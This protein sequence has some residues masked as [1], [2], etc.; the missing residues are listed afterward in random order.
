[1]KP[2][3]IMSRLAL[4]LIATLASSGLSPLALAQFEIEESPVEPEAQSASDVEPLEAA[5][6]DSE[7]WELP[8]ILVIRAPRTPDRLM[9]GVLELV[10]PVGEIVD[11]RE[12]EREARRSGLSATADA[13]LETMLQGRDITLIIIV[14]RR[15]VNR[16]PVVALS[17]REGRFGTPLLSAEHPIFGDTIPDRVAERIQAETVLAVTALT[18]SSTSVNTDENDRPNSP[19]LAGSTVQ[20]G[21]SAAGGVGSRGFEGPL[22][23][24]SVRLETGLFPSASMRIHTRY[25]PVARGRFAI[26]AELGYLTSVGLQTTDTR[27]DG[28][29]RSTSSRAQRLDLGMEFRYRLGEAQTAVTLGL[30]AGYA[31]RVFDTE[32]PV[33][34]PDYS[35]GSGTF[36]LRVTIPLGSERFALMLGPM[37]EWVFPIGEGLNT[38][39]PA[40]GL[41]FGGAA[42]LTVGLTSAWLLQ[43]AYQ[44]SHV[45]LQAPLGAVNDVERFATLGIIYAP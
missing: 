28:S 4:A 25:E 37:L 33:S 18:R 38:A 43:L 1:M 40:P 29:T 6:E 32:A 7:D 12:F 17:Y 39:D 24:G 3:I 26:Q 34:L 22:E 11:W 44:E 31:A 9:R 15:V 16:R 19:A 13:T 35:L 45:S 41:A 21:V 8:K 27:I 10:A 20:F 2:P 36:A 30:W 23:A 5:E 14:G 42:R